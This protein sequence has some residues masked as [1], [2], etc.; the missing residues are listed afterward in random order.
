MKYVEIPVYSITELSLASV[1]KAIE[2]VYEVAYEDEYQRIMD[3]LSIVY[4]LDDLVKFD[5][6]P[7]DTPTRKKFFECFA[8]PGDISAMIFIYNLSNFIETELDE[9]KVN[10]QQYATEKGLLFFKDGTIYNENDYREVT[11]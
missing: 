6:L 9:F 3:E 8:H 2:N 10:G 7:T 4:D 1:H 11:K 5:D